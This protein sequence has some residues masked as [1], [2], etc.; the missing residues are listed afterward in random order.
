MCLFFIWLSSKWKRKIQHSH[1][2]LAVS[3]NNS[4][5]GKKSNK[6]FT[7]SKGYTEC[8]VK[9]EGFNRGVFFSVYISIFA[10]D[11]FWK[12]T[13]R[14]SPH[15]F[16][17]FHRKIAIVGHLWKTQPTLWK[18]M[19]ITAMCAVLLPIVLQAKLKRFQPNQGRIWTF[20]PLLQWIEAF[21]C[22]L[23]TL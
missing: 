20:L 1:H 3:I 11:V 13:W 21:T 2:K 23:L 16:T 5:G 22:S 10:F 12:T 19:Q 9:W 15:Y 8:V 17:I 18:Y 14:S 4:F 6:S 7:I